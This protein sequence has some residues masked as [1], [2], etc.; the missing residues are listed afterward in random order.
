MDAG[1]SLWDRW[2]QSAPL[3][4]PPTNDWPNALRRA[5]IAGFV[6][7]AIQFLA[8]CWWS[9]VVASRFALTRDFALCEQAAWEIAHGHLNPFSTTVG[10]HF[11]QDHAMFIF[12]PIAFI[13]ALWPHP[14]SLLWIQNATLVAAEAVALVWMCDIAAAR[15]KGSPRASVAL[16]GIGLILMIG[17]PWTAWALSFDFHAES[18]SML[19]A[20]LVAR[21][22]YYGKKSLWAWLVFA[23]LCGDL[24][25]MWVAM[26]GVSAILIGRRW[27]RTSVILIGVA[28]VWLVLMQA[29]GSGA[30]N[31]ASI[32]GAYSPLLANGRGI[33]PLHPS[34]FAVV[35]AI[36][37]HPGRTVSLLWQNRANLWGNTSSAG[38]IGFLWPPLLIPTLAVLLEG[39]L[40]Y[41]AASFAPPGSQNLSLYV[42]IA[43]GTV[44]ACGALL[45]RFGNTRRW[46]LPVVIGVIT[47]NTAIWA[48]T[49]FPHVANNWLRVTPSAARVLTGV[50]RQISAQDEVVASQGVVGGFAE[51]QSVYALMDSP[52][53]VPVSARHI[54]VVL[55]P[56]QG[57][58]TAPVDGVYQDIAALRAMPFARLI[59]SSNGIWAFEVTPPAG[60]R[61]F[62]VPTPADGRTPAWTIVG[63]SGESA[64]GG[65][66]S[67]SPYVVSTS[68]S[69][70]VID[71][72]YWR[73]L[74]GTYKA[75]VSMSVSQ[76]ASFEV[77][78]STTNTLIKRTEV[79]DTH[80]LRTFTTAFRLE[81]APLEYVYSGWGLWSVYPSHTLG[82]V[83]EIRV[84]SPGGTGNVKVRS[85]A[86]QRLSGSEI[87]INKILGAAQSKP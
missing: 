62:T 87:T 60:M 27:L 56:I 12:W 25:T 48:A 76:A 75:S 70:Y 45:A 31:T 68:H 30:A 21:S 43:V 9:S 8:L 63:A 40:S 66:G 20:I 33:S 78:N 38:L 82:D 42:W 53:S 37:R 83:M 46:L 22:L 16:V 3:A 72:A 4:V 44:A 59:S 26:L 85:V 71:Q 57:I 35:E 41:N 54:W 1:K 84:W 13:Q 58:E 34:A 11:W 36:L 77:W 79:G 32:A 29:L 23:L 19:A 24:A 52:I 74:P 86:F 39:G 18:I 7:L 49:W 17:N 80:G 67:P 10:Y 65:A 28:A 6:L 50:Q 15:G 69:G 2:N 51:H 5:R 81:S 64:G 73:E 47:V 55:A 14:E 61:A